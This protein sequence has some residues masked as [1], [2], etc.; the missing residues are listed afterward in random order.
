MIG[1]GGDPEFA[2]MAKGSELAIPAHARGFSPKQIPLPVP[3]GAGALLRDGWA[4][5]LNPSYSSCRESFIYYTS[6]CMRFARAHLKP[7][8]ELRPLPVVNINTHYLKDAPEDTLMSGCDKSWNAYTG[9]EEKPALDLSTVDF[10]CFGGHVHLSGQGTRGEF[11][12]IKNPKYVY[13]FIKMVDRLV[14]IP[15]TY[16]L[17]SELAGV[18]RKFYGQAGEFRYQ[19]H[20]GNKT[21]LEYRVWGPEVYGNKVMMSLHLGMIRHVFGYFNQMAQSYD[22]TYEEQ[23]RSAINAGVSDESLLDLVV[24]IKQYIPDIATLKL[25]KTVFGK[26][27]H[28]PIVG[29]RCTYN[30][31]DWWA[32]RRGINIWKYRT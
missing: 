19:H 12:W 4:I 17:G 16:I 27:K 5:E 29:W 21:A 22:G 15:N 23:V 20:F 13:M 31:W 3:N 10:R 11:D 7:G 9:R 14:T 2:I 32:S 26:R 28:A 24:P 6:E 30:G 8:E 18:R 1:V 25:A